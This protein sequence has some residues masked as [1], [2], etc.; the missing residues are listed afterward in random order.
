MD[1]G[2]HRLVRRAVVEPS[3]SLTRRFMGIEIKGH[4]I[5]KPD[6]GPKTGR[7]E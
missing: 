6:A 2:R 1:H 7:P 3:V 4:L 5:W